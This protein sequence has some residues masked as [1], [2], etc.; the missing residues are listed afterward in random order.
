MTT[1]SASTS[2]AIAATA[3]L[4]MAT[5]AGCADSSSSAGELGKTP[6]AAPTPAWT[7]AT[8]AEKAEAYKKGEDTIRAYIASQLSDSMKTTST[9]LALD[10]FI[11]KEQ[12]FIDIAK[13]AGR[14]IK[15]KQLDLLSINPVDYTAMPIGN[16][17]IVTCERLAGGIYDKKGKNVEVTPD[18]K[19]QSDKPRLV[20]MRYSLIQ[21]TSSGRMLIEY[22]DPVST[23]D[24]D[25]P[26]PC[27]R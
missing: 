17:I 23:Y 7:K 9:S 8:D 4:V 19:P 21:S 1:R 2:L 13:S 22:A 24:P 27:T 15:V 26:K 10:P 20:G 11:V 3:V 12:E 18:G 16:A 25:P 14:T 6:S 5:A